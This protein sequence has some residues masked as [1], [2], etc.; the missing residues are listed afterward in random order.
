MQWNELRERVAGLAIIHAAENGDGLIH[1]VTY[2]DGSIAPT[3]ELAKEALEAAWLS[4]ILRI[5]PSTPVDAF[6]WENE[7][8]A[9]IGASWYPERA[10]YF[11]A[12]SGPLEQRLAD[13]ASALRQSLQLTELTRAER[14]SLRSYAENLVI[15]EAIRY[16]RTSLNEHN[17]PDPADHHLEAL[18]THTRRGTNEFALGHLYRMIWSCVRDANSAHERN[19]GMSREKAT[20]HAVNQFA[21]WVQRAVDDPHLLSEPF[22]ERHDLP[23][24][25]LTD[26]VFR[27]ILGE[28]PMSVS[29]QSVDELV[30]RHTVDEIDAACDARIPERSELLELLHVSRRDWD[31]DAFRAALAAV[32]EWR[33]AAC[34]ESCAHAWVPALAFDT[35]RLFDR[36]ATRAGSFAGQI[37]AESTTLGNVGHVCRPGDLLLWE[38]TKRLGLRDLDAQDGRLD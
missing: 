27:I 13:T 7:D 2:T 38:I 3:P 26:V 6:T 17:L 14:E 23:L 20:T 31:D 37:T 25:H 29:P 10:R 5:H 28:D 4:G 22:H 1:P 35:A 30:D 11:A 32:V 9:E 15:G 24:S 19:R 8:A 18:L 34:S 36:I 21:R 33:P 12:G 16:F